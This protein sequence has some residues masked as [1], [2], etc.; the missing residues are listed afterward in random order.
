MATK[1]ELHAINLYTHIGKEVGYLS[2][3]AFMICV[4]YSQV[5]EP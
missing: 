4:K 3:N 2:S 5:T 1:G